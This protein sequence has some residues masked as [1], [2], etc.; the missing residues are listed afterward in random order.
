MRHEQLKREVIEALN[1][2]FGDRSV[3]QEQTLESL[4]EIQSETEIFIDAIN[5][6]LKH[7]GES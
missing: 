3:S 2:L 6:D 5:D 7:R 1:K 4:E